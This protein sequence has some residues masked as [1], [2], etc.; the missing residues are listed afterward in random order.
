MPWRD[1]TT[2]KVEVGPSQAHR[3]ADTRAF[4]MEEAVKHTPHERHGFGDEELAV[5]V[6]IEPPLGFAGRDLREKPGR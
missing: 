4:A 2:L 1:R 6:G 5:F 3:F